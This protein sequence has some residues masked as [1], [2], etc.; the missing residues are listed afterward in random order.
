MPTFMETNTCFPV[1]RQS[2]LTRGTFS[3]SKLQQGDKN[4]KVWSDVTDHK[5]KPHKRSKWGK[6]AILSWNTRYPDMSQ[7]NDMDF[8]CEKIRYKEHT[9]SI[10]HSDKVGDSSILD[11]IA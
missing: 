3:K 8:V 7:M 1:P 6:I 5:P 4:R 10:S 11:D 9:D 2:H